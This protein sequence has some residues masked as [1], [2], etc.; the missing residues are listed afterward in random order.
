MNKAYLYATSIMGIVLLL[1]Q[2]LYLPFKLPSMVAYPIA[3]GFVISA[4]SLNM[5]A[6]KITT[7]LVKRFG[8]EG[9][10]SFLPYMMMKKLGTKA[11]LA[12]PFFLLLPLS[13]FG[14]FALHSSTGT[15]FGFLLLVNI[16]IFMDYWNNHQIEIS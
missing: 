9:E 15:P 12:L 10:S 1:A 14:W 11:I 4:F 16:L 2:S 13:L 8:L 5:S 3:I 7:R 6:A